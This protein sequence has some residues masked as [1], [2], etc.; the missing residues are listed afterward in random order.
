MKRLSKKGFTLNEVPA[1]AIALLI[2]AI[3]IGLG[4]T[5]LVNM[6]ETSTMTDTLSRFD[7]NSSFVGLNETFVNFAN[8]EWQ[9]TGAGYAYLVPGSCSGVVIVN[10]N[11][12]DTTANFTVVGCTANM[13]KDDGRHNT[14]FTANY[15]LSATGYNTNYNI[16]QTGLEGQE[17]FS[18]WQSTWVVILAAAVI[19]G[20]VGK[21]LFF[22]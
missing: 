18:D 1:L 2:V 13:T 20:I 15:T 19:I 22:K 5:V 7:D 10:E 21:Y 9:Y 6:Q 14:P 16:T 3:V 17:D 8:S 4:A 11:N 12:E